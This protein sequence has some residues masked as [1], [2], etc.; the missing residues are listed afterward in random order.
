MSVT[1]KITYEHRD[2][3]ETRAEE[4]LLQSDNEPTQDEIYDAV[5]RD[6]ARLSSPKPGTTAVAGGNDSN[7][8]IVFYVQIMPDDLVMQLHRF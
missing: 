1:Y 2:G 5:R 3:N 7:L 8:L 6:T 4:V